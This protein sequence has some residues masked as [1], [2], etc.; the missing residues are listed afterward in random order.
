MG[1]FSGPEISDRSLIV[2]FDG[3]NSR[4]YLNSPENLALYSEEFQV[5]NWNSSNFGSN[6]TVTANS[7]ASPFGD[8][9]ADLLLFVPN[10]TGQSR[11][12]QSFSFASGV[13]TNSVFVKKGTL[14][15]IQLFVTFGQT[16][17]PNISYNFDTDTITSNT[18]IINSG[19]T[20]YPDGWVRI[21][22]TAVVTSHSGGIGLLSTTSGT[23]YAWGFQCERGS[24]VNDYVKTT[25]SQFTHNTTWTSLIPTTNNGTLIQRPNFT[26]FGSGSFYFD[27]RTNYGSYI[28]LQSNFFNTSLPDF[29]I[30]SW[31][32][33]VEH[34]TIIGNH[35]G[36]STWETM[37][38]DTR[39]FT[40]NAANNNTTNR[41]TLEYGQ[42]INFNRWNNIVAVNSRN[43]SFMKV[44]I[45]GV[46]VVSN[47]FSVL[48]WNS[49]IFPTIG[50]IR[51]VNIAGGT[52][53][54]FNG[55]ISQ[56]LVYNYSLSADEIR[57]NY[58]SFR[59]RYLQ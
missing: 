5:S 8:V 48:P 35:Y 32:Y 58:N 50:T 45:N 52:S 16:P 6:A 47:N 10:S 13:Y 2:A 57:S 44:Y 56:I 9:T 38:F 23:V 21:W 7:I 25:T 22:A 14:S 36:N 31:V 53:S 4:G 30:S 17:F 18:G 49:S 12:Q 11:R 27:G 24:G 1:V 3:I 42:F 59:S 54:H 15:I 19:R 55:Y 43:R 29:T 20:L 46:E 33:P 28:A 37:W 40:V 34:G 51:L 26:S 41:Q 39:F